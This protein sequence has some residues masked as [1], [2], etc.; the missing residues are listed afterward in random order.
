MDGCSPSH[1]SGDD[2]VRGRRHLHEYRN[3]LRA[4]DDLRE[5][6]PLWALSVLEWRAGDSDRA[7]EYAHELLSLAA[8]SGSEHSEPT[9]I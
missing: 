8:Q 7:A 6:E 9:W 4:R 3:T 2:P 5:A 1:L